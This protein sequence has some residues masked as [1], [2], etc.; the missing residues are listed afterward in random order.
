MI[1]RLGEVHELLFIRTNVTD[2]DLQH[3]GRLT[4]LETLFLSQTEVTGTGLASLQG[5]SNLRSLSLEDTLV[6]EKSIVTDESI[7]PNPRMTELH[8]LTLSGRGITNAVVAR[9]S[10]WPSPLGWIGAECDSG[11]I[12]GID[13]LRSSRSG[14]WA[15]TDDDSLFVE[16]E[17]DA[18]GGGRDQATL[19]QSDV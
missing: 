15:A 4:N 13:R 11:G 1:S 12:R 2:E 5:L 10:A 8:Y 18:G 17:R 6:T 19:A 14:V 9:L 7:R 16:R 3:L